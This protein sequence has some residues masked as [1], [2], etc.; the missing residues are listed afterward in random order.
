M[1][2]KKE[3]P[4]DHT[5]KGDRPERIK[6]YSAPTTTAT[7]TNKTAIVHIATK[8]A[9]L[10]SGYEREKSKARSF[11]STQEVLSKAA[12]AKVELTVCEQSR[13]LLFP[14]CGNLL[15]AN[16]ADEAARNDSVLHADAI[17]RF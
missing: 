17:A 13:K 4:G 5:C 12:K 1:P 16:V 9:S 7:T 10:D 11:L 8:A 6:L 14:S 3:T 15:G 2:E